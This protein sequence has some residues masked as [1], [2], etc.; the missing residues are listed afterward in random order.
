M[1]CCICNVR[2]A[3]DY[4][5]LFSQSKLNKKLYPEFIHHSDNLINVCNGC[6]LNKTVPKWTEQEFCG[7]F[8]IE[9]RSKSGRQKLS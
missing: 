7:H 6:H 5:H 4:H 1:I 2:L 9:I 3:T 8:G